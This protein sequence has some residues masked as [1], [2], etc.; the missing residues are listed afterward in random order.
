MSIAKLARLVLTQALK[1][2]FVTESIY[3]IA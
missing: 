2:Y 1:P 3:E